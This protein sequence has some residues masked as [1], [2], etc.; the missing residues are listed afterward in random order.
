MSRIGSFLVAAGVA[1]VLLGVVLW[2]KGLEGRSLA[3]L[4]PAP[5]ATPDVGEVVF[6]EPPLGDGTA[7]GACVVCHAVD[8][9]DGSRAAPDLYGIV[10]AEKAASPWFNYSTA[11]R[12]AD[13][14]WT[15]ADLDDYLSHPPSF[16]PG[17]KKTIVGIA[18][19][20]QRREIIEALK[21]TPANAGAN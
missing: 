16:L 13:G 4:P 10:G 5:P 15:E 19:P 12:A 14:V 6:A 7:L 2:G 9:A 11:L 17:T 21:A 8:P 20:A 18:D 1:G 3:G